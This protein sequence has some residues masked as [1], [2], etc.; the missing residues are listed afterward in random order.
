MKDKILAAAKKYPKN[1]T[2]VFSNDDTLFHKIM[3]GT[4]FFLMSSRIEA[5]ALKFQYALNYGSIPIAHLVGGIKDFAHPIKSRLTENSNCIA[6]NSLNDTIL[7][8]SINTAL[9]LFNNKKL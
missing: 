1:V 9:D 7:I 8:K 6:M 2:V 3:A 4:D 5:D